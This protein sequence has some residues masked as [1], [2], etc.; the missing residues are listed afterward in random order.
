MK[1]NGHNEVFFSLRVLQR[2]GNSR[3]GKKEKRTKIF[4]L[5]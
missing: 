3:N 1:E 5:S 2:Q 4:N